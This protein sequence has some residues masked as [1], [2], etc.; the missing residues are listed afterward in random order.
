MYV[1][2][3]PSKSLLFFSVIYLDLVTLH[4]NLPRYLLGGKHKL[5]TN[6]GTLCL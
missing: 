2:K 6:K 1:D 5:L 3:F 4:S